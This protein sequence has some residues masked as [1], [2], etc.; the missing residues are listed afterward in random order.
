M[1][2]EATIGVDIGGTKVLGVA[3]GADGSVVADAKVATPGTGEELMDV[4]AALVTALSV[5]TP[6]RAV[7]GVGVGAPGL[8]DAIGVLRAAPNLAGMAGLALRTGLAA[9]LP[10]IPVRMGNDATFAAWAEW[11]RGAAR[12]ASHVVLVT[13]GTGI[14]GGMV[15]DGIL[16]EGTHGYAGEFGHMVVDPHG[17]ACP[18]G[19]RGCW[20]RFASGSALAAMGRRAAEIGHAA[21]I[22]QL[23]GGDPSA[24]QGEHVTR[25]AAEGDPASVTI[26][27]EFGWWVALGLANL[28][29][30]LDPDCVVVGGGL[31]DAWPVLLE[32]VMTVFTA[33]V[34]GFEHRS[35]VRL[36]P[37]ELG[38]RAGAIG[39]ALLAR[40]LG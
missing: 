40:R 5:H 19:K 24:V 36:V 20:E 39:A 25:A 10:G 8:V 3:V 14:G 32:P 29:N 35:H 11:E 12:G 31:V 15:I 34:E 26:V 23:A 16:I 4:V 38:E 1:G 28:V 17:P 33:Q 27:A 18:C 21:R 37:A 30:L 22:L 9:R 7:A 6:G 13:L 2:D